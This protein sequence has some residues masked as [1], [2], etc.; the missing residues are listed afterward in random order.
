MNAAESQIEK[1][2]DYLYVGR[3]EAWITH[4]INDIDTALRA[5]GQ[6]P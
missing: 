1:G 5:Q 3:A 4:S 6:Q 2:G